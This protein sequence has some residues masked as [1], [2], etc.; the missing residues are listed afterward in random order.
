[1]ARKWILAVAFYAASTFSILAQVRETF[2]L[3][4]FDAPVGWNRET[5]D[6]AL[7]FV[8]TNSKSRGWCRI[9]IYKSQTGSGDA[10]HD[11]ENEWQAIVTKN[12]PDAIRPTPEMTNEEGWTSASG[13][14]E[15]KW[16]NENSFLLLTTITGHGA[17]IT[18][19]VMMNSNEFMPQVESFLGA[20]ELQ[21]PALSESTTM[22]MVVEDAGNKMVETVDD[23]G[24][25]LSTTNFDDGWVARPFKDYVKLSKGE[26]TVLLHYAVQITD[27]MRNSESVERS[28]WNRLIEPRYEISNLAKYDNGGPCYFCIYFF[29]ADAVDRQSGKKVYLGFR[30]LIENG[31]ARCIEI[32]SPSKAE[33]DQQ[34]PNQEKIAALTGYNKFAVAM[35]DIVG[36]WEES[37]GS[38]VDMYNTVTGSYAGMNTAS[39]A[40]TFVF[41]ADGSYESHHSGAYGMVGNM[42]FFDQKYK[43]KNTL[44]YWEMALT[45]RF[46]GKT[47]EFWVQFEAVKGGRVLHLT[48]KTASG[49]QYHLVKTR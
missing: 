28:L 26:I 35:Q 2:D 34:F 39:S 9:T 46:E 31:I 37:G 44:T 22:Q 47:D 10:T 14:S 45:N 18:I 7:S 43:G 42:Q 3:V 30:V 15:F 49:I 12:Y 40:H 13:V 24:I 5:T 23:H 11:F 48:D 4:T 16:Q 33:L 19:M 29:E 6:Y 41:N 27:E 36:T 17:E 21:K 8:T 32:I 38:Y 1:M 20:I 25:S